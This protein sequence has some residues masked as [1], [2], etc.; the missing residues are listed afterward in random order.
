M[1]RKDNKLITPGLAMAA[2]TRVGGAGEDE[3]WLSRVIHCSEYRT[4]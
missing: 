4:R 2:V 3:L 1:V